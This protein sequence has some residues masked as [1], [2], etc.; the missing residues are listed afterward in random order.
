MARTRGRTVLDL[1]CPTR[2]C[3]IS[4]TGSCR[5]PLISSCSRS[6]DTAARGHVSFA[7]DFELR[8]YSETVFTV[9]LQRTIRVLEPDL[10]WQICLCRRPNTSA[11]L[12]T[13]H[14]NSLTN[15]G[16]TDWHKEWAVSLPPVGMFNPS[17]ATTIV[18]PIREGAREHAWQERDHG[19]LRRDPS[20]SAQS[21]GPRDLPARRWK[22]RS[23]IGINPRRSL[24]KLGS[25]DARDHVLTIVQFDQ[26]REITDY[27]NS[28]GTSRLT[29]TAA[30]S[31]TP[32]TWMAHLH[33]AL[34]RWDR[35]S[36]WSRHPPP[37]RWLP[38]SVEPTSIH[39][40]VHPMI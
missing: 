22:Y 18:I 19:L 10:A 4:R 28:C 1:L 17:P 27:V 39:P 40:W 7:S 16:A 31:R 11:S 13:S 12:R 9:R 20:G 30:M 8:N 21:D 23:K 14:V 5:V 29:P 24:A 15:A 37:S 26:P 32:T 2:G 25:Y 38:V 34:R 6:P 36:S 33:P 35:L 3:S